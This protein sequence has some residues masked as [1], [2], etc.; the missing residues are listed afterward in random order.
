MVVD[1]HVHFGIPNE[2]AGAHTPVKYTEEMLLEAM[3]VAGVDV[4]VIMPLLQVSDYDYLINAYKR[5]PRKFIPVAMVD[6]W[7]F[8][9]IREAVQRFFDMGFRGIKL[10]PTGQ[11]FTIDDYY[12]L[13]PL[14]EICSDL[15]L[16][17]TIHTGED[18]ANTP[19]QCHDIAVRYPQLTVVVAHAGWRTLTEQAIEAARRCPNIILDE[20]SGHSLQLRRAVEELGPSRIVMGSDSP[21]MDVRVEIV[22]VR[23]AVEDHDAQRAILGENAMKVWKEK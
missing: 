8:A 2:G 7:A 17:I 4:S 5:H 11:R 14:Y 21:Y 15:A 18:V 12:F 22:K 10:R 16:P 20:T 6:P 9:D 13:G 3:E 1:A 23:T 19:L